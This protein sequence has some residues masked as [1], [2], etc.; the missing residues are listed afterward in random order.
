MDERMHKLHDMVNRGIDEITAKGSLD[1]DSVCLIYKL[2]DIRKDLSTIEAMEE[3]GYSEEMGYSGDGRRGRDGDGDGRYSE[4][5]YSRRRGSY[6]RG[7][8]YRRYY[9]DGYSRGGK[10]QMIEHLEQAMAN[11]TTEQERQSIQR[12]IMNIENG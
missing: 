1:K 4:G 3:Y 2:V 7:G 8:S 12:M 9:D 5:R 6:N 11:A 10:E